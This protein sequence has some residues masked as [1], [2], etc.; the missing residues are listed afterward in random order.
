MNVIFN[1]KKLNLPIKDMTFMLDMAHNDIGE[2]EASYDES[3]KL[4]FRLESTYANVLLELTDLT[5]PSS[6]C[7]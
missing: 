3:D 6:H 5:N 2:L 1:P 7:I 4:A